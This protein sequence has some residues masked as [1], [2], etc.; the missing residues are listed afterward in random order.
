LIQ[1]GQ[2]HHYEERHYGSAAVSW[3]DRPKTLFGQS[4]HPNYTGLILAMFMWQMLHLFLLVNVVQYIRVM[5]QALEVHSPQMWVAAFLLLTLSCA[6]ES[7][8]S[9]DDD[10]AT[11]SFLEGIKSVFIDD[12]SPK[13]SQTT[14]VHIDG[15]P[16]EEAH[17]R[18]I[19]RIFIDPLSEACP[20][21]PLP[22]FSGNPPLNSD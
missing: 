15:H 9:L 21:A 20:T 18:A 6:Q 5:R 13:S 12:L 8:K 22:V 3:G 7:A 14:V 2:V 17:S 4:F 10:N 11:A 16:L 1:P 19:H